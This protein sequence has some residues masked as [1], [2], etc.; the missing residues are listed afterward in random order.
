M[1]GKSK[2]I[3][4][5]IPLKVWQD[6][7]SNPLLIF[8]G[9]ICVVY[10]SCWDDDGVPADYICKITFNS[11]WASRFYGIEYLPYEIKEFHCSSIY[12]V[13][14]S[15]WLKESSERRLQ[16]YPQWKTWDKKTYHH[17]VVSG[18]DDY[19]EIIAESFTEEIIPIES[20]KEM[21]PL[22]YQE[23]ISE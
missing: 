10:I 1:F 12:E 2:E 20:A 3:A 22:F 4:V 8:S 16:Y 21:L 5:A 7:Q 13:K 11:G 18:H 6:P 23:V 9:S 15:K 14:D 19:V 17:F